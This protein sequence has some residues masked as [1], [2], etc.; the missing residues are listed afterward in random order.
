MCKL[1]NVKQIHHWA[2]SDKVSEFL[3]ERFAIERIPTE[4]NFRGWQYATHTV[5]QKFPIWPFEM[6]IEFHAEDQVP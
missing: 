5:T 6:V 1:E 3:K 2:A 4:I